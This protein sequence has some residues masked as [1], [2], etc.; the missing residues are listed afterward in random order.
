MVVCIRGGR[1]LQDSSPLDD[2]DFV[3]GTEPRDAAARSRPAHSLRPFR[4]T[5]ALGFVT[6]AQ[7]RGDRWAWRW[8]ETRSRRC[9]F[10]GVVGQEARWYS[11]T[12]LALTISTALL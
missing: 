7:N 6:G 5:V 11:V 1:G 4:T 10:C 3:S 8:S 2:F 9:P 12:I